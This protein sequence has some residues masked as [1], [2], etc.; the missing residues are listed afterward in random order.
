MPIKV[1]ILGAKLY[2][3]LLLCLLFPKVKQIL[4]AASPHSLL[5]EAPRMYLWIVLSNDIV[6][7][8]HFVK[9]P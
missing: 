6:G 1:D 8:L 3:V 4:F 9:S 5:T 7:T 2:L